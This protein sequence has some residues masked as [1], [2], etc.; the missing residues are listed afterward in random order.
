MLTDD[1]TAPENSTN[2][3]SAQLEPNPRRGIRQS[4]HDAVVTFGRRTTVSDPTR[5]PIY[6]SK[7]VAAREAI[8]DADQILHLFGKISKSQVLKGT[9]DSVPRSLVR[10]PTLEYLALSESQSKRQASPFRR[11][12]H[13]K[14]LELVSEA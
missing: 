7:P 2:K 3:L 8:Q 14:S 4:R 5:L 1:L 13:P 6:K 9:L 11:G 10:Q 12:R